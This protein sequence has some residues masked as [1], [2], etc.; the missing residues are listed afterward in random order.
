[1]RLSSLPD[2]AIPRNIGRRTFLKAGVAGSALLLAGRWLPA[3][4]VAAEVDSPAL[5]YLGSADVVMLRRVVPVVLAGAL[6][7]D[8]ASQAGAIDEILQGIDLVIHH[9]SLAVRGEIADLFGLLTR[10]VTR[11]LVAGVWSSWDEASTE[12]VQA[13]LAGW[14]DSRFTLLRSAYLGLQQLVVASW[15]GNP[16]SWPRIGYGGPPKLA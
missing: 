4:G 8:P 5:R 14:R 2:A 15:Y 10:G 12:E 11:T 16:R 9:Q 7:Q 1:M 3:P 13:F 6:P